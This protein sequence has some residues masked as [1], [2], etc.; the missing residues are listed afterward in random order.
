MS[1]F[2]IPPIA[3]SEITPREVF[4]NRRQFITG[5]AALGIGGAVAGSLATLA[6]PA[7]EAAEKLQTV[8]GK[9]TTTGEPLTPYGKVTAPVRGPS[10]W[11]VWSSS[12]VPSTLTAF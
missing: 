11:R 3:S 2:R 8:P 9:F 4:A 1:R 6:A 5:A 12:R 7:V 10:R